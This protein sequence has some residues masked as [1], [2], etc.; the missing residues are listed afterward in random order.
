MTL[1]RKT[2]L[3]TC[4]VCGQKTDKRDLVRV[5]A[6]PDG[7]IALD[8]TGKA[9]GR[10]A[11]VCGNDASVPHMLKKGRLEHALRTNIEDKNWLEIEASLRT[12]DNS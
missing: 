8:A 9:S 4:I 1:K 12:A 6:S 11:Y 7:G 5:V 2:P 3:R 10:G